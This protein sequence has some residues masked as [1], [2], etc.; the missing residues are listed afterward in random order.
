MGTASQARPRTRNDPE[1]ERRSRARDKIATVA[2]HSIFR[3]T[4]RSPST[5]TT[6]GADTSAEQVRP[7]ALT[8]KAQQASLPVKPSPPSLPPQP[9]PPQTPQL[10][11]QHASLV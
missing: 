7:R 8:P 3:S 1:T 5:E 10:I 4:G 2:A 6:Q 11:G 9:V